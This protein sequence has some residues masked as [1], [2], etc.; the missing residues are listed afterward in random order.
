MTRCKVTR[1]RAG[2]AG[3]INEPR[4]HLGRNEL[5]APDIKL[6]GPRALASAHQT[7]SGESAAE[8]C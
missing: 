5:S 3:M 6:G 8:E 4:R 1:L 7:E 2:G